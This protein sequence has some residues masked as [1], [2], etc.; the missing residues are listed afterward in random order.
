MTKILGLVGSPRRKGNT[1][2]LIDR[3]LEGARDAGAEVEK[4][5]LMGMKIKECD[6]CHTCW[7]GKR[8]SKHDDMLDL[9]PAIE[10]ADVIVFGTPVYWF[11]PTALMKAFIDRLVYFNC[12]D[13]RP[14]I[15]GK[16]AVIASPF[17]DADMET[18]STLVS[19]FDKCFD[20]LEMKPAGRILVPGVADRGDILS[21][22]DVLERAYKLGISLAANNCD[23]GKP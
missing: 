8:C 13:N 21:K 16:A 9:Y 6:G 22:S 19:F 15:A 1:D 12:P 5:L 14:K 11:G 4:V 7:Q 2:I 20:Y 18:A 23:R 10:G 17:E 3:I